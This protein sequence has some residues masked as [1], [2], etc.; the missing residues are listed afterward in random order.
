MAKTVELGNR[1]ASA[2]VLVPPVLLAVY[3]GSPYFDALI[4]LILGLMIFEWIRLSRSDK[5]RM[6]AGLIYIVSACYFLAMLRNRGDDGREILIWLLC[7]VWAT[8]TA[9][10]FVGRAIGG[11]KLAPR[12]SPGKT[13]SGA[14]GGLGG[15]LLAGYIGAEI[16]NLA[17]TGRMLTLSAVASIACQLGDLLESGAKRHFEVKNSGNLIPGH[18]GILDRLDGLL[19]TGLIIGMIDLFLDGRIWTWD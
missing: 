18:G 17:G 1:V 13:I 10:Y 16:M 3:F 12:L 4:A 9:A 14:A 11:P 5:I 15:G 7:V 8:D 19:A 6:A 2:I